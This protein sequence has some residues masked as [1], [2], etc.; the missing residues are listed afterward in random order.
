MSAWTR[1]K[2]DLVES[3]ISAIAT[4][5][6]ICEAEIQQLVDLTRNSEGS[7]REAFEKDLEFHRKKQTN[8]QEEKSDRI[9]EK[10]SWIDTFQR[11]IDSDVLSAKRGLF[12][13]CITFF[14]RKSFTKFCWFHSHASV[15]SLNFS[16][17]LDSGW[18]NSAVGESTFAIAEILSRTINGSFR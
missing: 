1:E 15:G 10:K 11:Q 18:N 13:P 8:L 12:W 3:E 17:L 6:A 14:G 16:E 5:I 4:K 2:I 9:K 7:I